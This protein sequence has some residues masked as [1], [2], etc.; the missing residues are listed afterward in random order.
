MLASAHLLLKII[1]SLIRHRTAF[2]AV[3]TNAL[4]KVRMRRY[5]TSVRNVRQMNYS[6]L[7]LGVLCHNTKGAIVVP[8]P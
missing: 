3:P 7:E 6:I 4:R 2:Q 8:S 5:K 1:Y